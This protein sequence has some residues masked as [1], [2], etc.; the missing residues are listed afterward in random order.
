MITQQDLENIIKDSI[1]KLVNE[2]LSNKNITK[3]YN[4]HQEK[5][6]FIPI[7]Y[8]II[9]GILQSL[10]IKFGN[11]LQN[12]LS[13]IILTEENLILHQLS[14]KKISS[15]FS[16]EVN[17][18][19]EEYIYDRENKEETEYE[20]NLNFSKLKKD[21]INKNKIN[22]AVIFFKQDIDLLFETR[23]QI[24]YLEIKYN[25]DHDTGK[26]ADINRKFI[27]T[28]LLIQDHI[29]SSSIKPIV[30]IIY[31]FNKRIRWQSHYIPR[32]NVL[33]G[34]QLFDKYFSMKFELL[35]DA[36]KNISYN[37]EFIKIFDDMSEKVKN[38][39]L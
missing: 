21:I 17:N 19:I 37:Q 11:F 13:E 32:E 3:Q 39:S 4:K 8:R 36:I 7:Q 33:R 22:N 24:I 34:E 38:L 35:E 5:I 1:I 26:F 29:A 12:L 15:S 6:H 18:I 31:Y 28:F 2:S 9:G 27:K 23:D 30:P 10:N 25:D 14:G 16:K 20:L